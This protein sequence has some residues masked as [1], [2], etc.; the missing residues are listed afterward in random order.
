[1][2]SWDPQVFKKKKKTIIDAHIPAAAGKSKQT[3]FLRSRDPKYNGMMRENQT[4]ANF[5]PFK[6]HLET[7]LR[8]HLLDPR[9][10]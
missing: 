3:I 5:L 8:L 6:L 9:S 2:D 10:W 4:K 7:G 1:M